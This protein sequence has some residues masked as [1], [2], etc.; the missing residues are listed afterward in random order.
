[1]SDSVVFSRRDF[2]KLVGVGV[3]G[4]AAGCGK[5]PAEKL[6]PYLVAP[7]D[8]LPGVPYYY[9][10]TCRECPVGCGLVAKSREGRTIIVVT[11]DE[12]TASYAARE[13]QIRDGLI[14][15]DRA[16]AGR[17]T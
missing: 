6:V 1:M 16:L 2:L 12:Q 15:S 8:I 10:S 11:H 7:E 9:A 17:P 13:L 5:P 4:A 3:A 14:A